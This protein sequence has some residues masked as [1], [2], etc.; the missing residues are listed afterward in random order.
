M[1]IQRALEDTVRKASASFPVML[2]TGPR[3]VGKSTMLERLAEPNRKIVTL[4]DPDIRY[5]AKSDPALFLQ[6]Y[7][8]PVLIDE[9]QYA[10]A[11]LFP[12]IKMAVD[13]SKRNGDFWITGSQAFVMMQNV[14]ESLAGRVGIINL[15]GLSTNEINAV[16]SE[17]FTTDSDRLMK[18]IEKV[19][20]FDLNSLYFRIFKG[21][22][23][24]L[25]A[26]NN[27]DI[28]MYYRSYIDSYLKRDIKDLTQVAD[29]MAFYNFMTVVAA[30]TAKPVVY[31]EIARECGISSPTAKKWL[32]ILM[33]SHIIA[34]VQPYYNNLLKR[35]T[36][37]P[38]LHFLDTGLCAHL[39]KWGNPEALERGA[40]SGAFFESYVFSEI[41]KSY[42][43]AGKEPP[44]YYYRDKD[45]KEIDLI[46]YENGAL[47]PIEIKK[48]ASPGKDAIKHFGVL[49]SVTEPEKFGE[50]SQ[51]KLK[52][53]NGAVVC[54]ANDLLPINAKN[55]YVPVWMI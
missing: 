48:S 25:Y 31:D 41:Y 20:K 11:E 50:L 14:S 43:N 34:L 26:D 21:S 27:V 1:Y 45:K 42:L 6:R 12:H 18:R 54:M 55:W 47:Y 4:D 16:S 23:P 28:E 33:S 22:M 37:T 44:I 49:E 38:M 35:V 51:T 17:V 24:K 9:I 3:Q 2:V 8:P 10:A 19:K 52:I 15:L 13:K 7:T 32:S 46:I 30:R 53:G 40:M 36:K 29:E 39:L 5:L